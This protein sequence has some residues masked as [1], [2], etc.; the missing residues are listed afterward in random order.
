MISNLITGFR[1]KAFESPFRRLRIRDRKWV[2][3]ICSEDGGISSHVNFVMMYL[4][5][6]EYSYD[7][8]REF[9]GCV[10]KKPWIENGTLYC[11]Y[12][13]GLP[14]KRKT[15]AKIILNIYAPICKNVVF[16]AVS[17]KNLEE[18]QE[19][20][21]EQITSIVNSPEAQNYVIDINEH[22]YLEGPQYRNMR[23]KS[24]RFH[25]HNNWTY[26]PITEENID[27]CLEVNAKWLDEHADIEGALQEQKSLQLALQELNELQLQGGLFR[28]DGKPA[29]IYIGAPFNKEIY[30]SLFMKADNSYTDIA[31]VFTNEFLKRNCPGFR[32]DNEGADNGI[33]GL[34]KFKTNMHPKFMTEFYYVTVETGK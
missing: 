13:I 17:E 2:E 5:Q 28:I 24:A 27:A 34:R 6:A 16:F 19:L 3:K 10:L 15:A 31:V 30:L 26:E 9:F 4:T 1:I 7:R 33:A 25:R 20:F 29:A 21:G 11:Q 14:D 12:P 18:L 8:F 23:K 32:Y 22:I